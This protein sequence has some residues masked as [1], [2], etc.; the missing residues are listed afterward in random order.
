MAKK[1]SKDK[2]LLAKLVTETED[3]KPCAFCQREID[4]EI[5]Y[6]KLYSIGNI[7]CHYFCVVSASTISVII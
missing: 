7:Q 2:K 6:G 5:T 1:V 3:R 4:D